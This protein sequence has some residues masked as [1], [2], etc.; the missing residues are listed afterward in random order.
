M[1]NAGLDEAQA[2]IKIAGR[3]I[4]NLRY[5]IWD[6]F[7]KIRDTKGTFHIKLG[8]TKDRK[9]MELREAEDLEYSSWKYIS[10]KDWYWSWSS[11]TL[12]TWCEELTHWKR[13]W[14]RERLKAGA[15]DNRGW[16]GWMVSL[17]QWTW[18]WINSGS[19]WDREAWH[20]AVHGVSKSWTQLSNW[21]ELIMRL[22]VYPIIINQL[23]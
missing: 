8:T 5:A 7:K 23:G 6:F 13:P 19:W 10:W 15:G 17:T 3:N 4:N 14:C 16:D 21:T 22:S 18:V 11:N 9:G 2:G 12:A 1:R 20:A